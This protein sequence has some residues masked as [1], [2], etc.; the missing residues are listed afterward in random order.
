MIGEQ[1]KL[2]VPHHDIFCNRQDNI[3]SKIPSESFSLIFCVPTGEYK[4]F[5]SM[6]GDVR[7]HS[8]PLICYVPTGEYQSCCLW[9]KHSK[10]FSKSIF[11]SHLLRSN[12]R[13]P[14]FLALTKP[15]AIFEVGRFIT[16]AKFQQESTKIFR[17]W[18]S[19]KQSS[20]LFSSQL[21]LA[22]FRVPNVLILS[23]STY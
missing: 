5:S 2:T 21:P 20:R 19:H 17:T 15:W 6:L 13:V 12:R 7:S 14:K 1:E 11:S 22:N 16:S 9:F 8:I 3:L 10:R 4:S 18:F 23:L